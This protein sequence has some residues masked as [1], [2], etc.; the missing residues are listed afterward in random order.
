MPGWASAS[1]PCTAMSS[2][3]ASRCRA[4][5][6]AP[7][8]GPSDPVPWWR[9]PRRARRPSPRS[10]PPAGG[11]PVVPAGGRRR[12]SSGATRA[13]SPSTQGADARGGRRTWSAD[14]D[15]RSAPEL[16]HRHAELAHR[17][18]RVDVQQG[19]GVAAAPGDL[20]GGLQRPDLVV[21]VLDVHGDRRGVHGVGD[22]V[23]VDHARAVDRHLDQV[24]HA[25]IGQATCGVEHRGV[26][27]RRDD[28]ATRGRRRA[29][30]DGPDGAGHGEVGGLGPAGGPHHVLVAGPQQLG[31]GRGGGL[32]QLPSRLAL[33][34]G[35]RRVAVG[36]RQRVQRGRVGRRHAAASQQRRRG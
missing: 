30:A 3:S 13:R 15:S 7:A 27:H 2:S 36:D 22:R 1:G 25:V 24:G 5:G 21:G 17:L 11:R 8:R 35:P 14:S 6:G 28:Q 26:L 9:R 16:G 29:P 31:R 32:E 18:A 19:P 20:V 12:R 34:V 23:E 10:P 33:H 4:G